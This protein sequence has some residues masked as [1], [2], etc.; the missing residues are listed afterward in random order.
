[1]YFGICKG[2]RL[3]LTNPNWESLR[4]E[5]FDKASYVAIE[6]GTMEELTLTFEDDPST[7]DL[8]VFSLLRTYNVSK[9]GESG[10]RTLT[11]FLRDASGKPVG[12]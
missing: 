8:E 7:E 9:A 11:L 10:H 2:T 4:P 6:G 3:F 1:M 5:Y 12:D